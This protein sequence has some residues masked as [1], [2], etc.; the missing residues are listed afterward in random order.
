MRVKA[1]Y[2]VSLGEVDLSET[3][4][5]RRDSAYLITLYGWKRAPPLDE[6]ISLAFWRSLTAWGP[7]TRK[8]S[9]VRVFSGQGG[10]MTKAVASSMDDLTRVKLP[11]GTAEGWRS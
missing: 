9:A 1:F 11:E 7:T 10:T 4:D 6:A 8:L 2:N 3:N 5:V